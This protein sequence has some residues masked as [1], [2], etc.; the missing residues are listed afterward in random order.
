MSS[1]LKCPVYLEEE[2]GRKYC[3]LLLISNHMGILYV[4]EVQR[5]CLS[6]LSF[7][8]IVG[9]KG[10]TLIVLMKEYKLHRGVGD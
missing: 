3:A 8:L 2:G 1:L 4:M 9:K 5:Y 6:L 10:I 7:L